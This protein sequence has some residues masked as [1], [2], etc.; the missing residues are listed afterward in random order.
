MASK[1]K[2]STDKGAARTS[3]D[4]GVIVL[5]FTPVSH[6]DAV[7]AEIADQEMMAINATS[8]LVPLNRD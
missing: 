2:V 7:A 3:P 4:P 8:N 6:A 5:P 1:A